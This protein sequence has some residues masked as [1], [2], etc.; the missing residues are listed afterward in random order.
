MDLKH[1]EVG[2]FDAIG[3]NT[4][5]ADARAVGWRRGYKYP[6]HGRPVNG[7]LFRLV[8]NDTRIAPLLPALG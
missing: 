8:H 4:A 1:R 6:L 3:R 2:D 7:W 5:A